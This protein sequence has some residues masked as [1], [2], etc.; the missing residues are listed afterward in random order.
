MRVKATSKGCWSLALKMIKI[1]VKAFTNTHSLLPRHSSE[2][3]IFTL[4]EQGLA[5]REGK[6][7]NYTKA[8]K[9]KSHH[10]QERNPRIS[11]DLRPALWGKTE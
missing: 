5:G 1:V 11:G 6:V 10:Y 8:W 2:L 3:R 7:S 9:R 4:L